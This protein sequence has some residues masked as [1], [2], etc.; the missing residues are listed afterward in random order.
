MA[1]YSIRAILHGKGSDVFEMIQE[2]L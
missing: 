1:M 2:N